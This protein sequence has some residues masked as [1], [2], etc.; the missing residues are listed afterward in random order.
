[1]EEAVELAE[2]GVAVVAEAANIYQLV[3][4]EVVGSARR[5]WVVLGEVAVVDLM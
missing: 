1:M 3:A 4:A 5:V 2:V